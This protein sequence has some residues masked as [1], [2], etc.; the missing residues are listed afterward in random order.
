MRS[1]EQIYDHT[2]ISTHSIEM[3]FESTSLVH[4]NQLEEVE[5]DKQVEEV[6]HVYKA[7]YFDNESLCLD[8]LFKKDVD[9]HTHTPSL[10]HIES[11]CEDEYDE[12]ELLFQ[13]KFEDG[14]CKFCEIFF[15]KE[16]KISSDY[17]E[18][19]EHTA[20]N[21]DDAYID[22]EPLFLYE[23][24]TVECDNSGEKTC[25]EDLKFRVLF[26]KENLI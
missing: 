13:T 22:N 10:E 7:C 1:E 16:P 12:D 18:R 3:P 6:L 15:I 20:K 21:C 11:L 17:V 4:L 26:E 24:F 23:L 2:D 19:M 9:T 5:E 25:I 8:N 14:F